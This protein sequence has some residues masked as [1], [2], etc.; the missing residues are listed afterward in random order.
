MNLNQLCAHK[1]QQMFTG[2]SI[3]ECR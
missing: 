3:H 1:S 2:K